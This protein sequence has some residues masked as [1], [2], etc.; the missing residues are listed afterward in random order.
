[1][2]V[3]TNSLP[4]RAVHVPNLL[5]HVRVLDPCA[6]QHLRAEDAMPRGGRRRRTPFLLRPQLRQGTKIPFRDDVVAVDEGDPVV[7]G[8]LDC[9]DLVP[10][11]PVLNAGWEQVNL[12]ALRMRAGKKWRDNG[13][14]RGEREGGGG[15]GGGHGKWRDE[16]KPTEGEKASTTTMRGRKA[17]E[18]N[19]RIIYAPDPRSS[20]KIQS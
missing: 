4:R 10:E 14:E 7:R 11:R 8:E 1:M 19:E 18:S 13:G 17:K 9:S 5:A 12:L 2:R 6:S 15:E 3:E 16:T 20:P